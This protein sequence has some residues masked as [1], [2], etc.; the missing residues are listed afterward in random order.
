MEDKEAWFSGFFGELDDEAVKGLKEKDPISFPGWIAG[1]ASEDDAKDYLKAMRAAE[2]NKKHK[3]VVIKVTGAPTVTALGNRLVCHRLHGA[4]AA[5]PAEA[6]GIVTLTI[7]ADKYDADDLKESI[8]KA[9]K[10]AEP[11]AP[12]APATTGDDNKGTAPEAENQ[13]AGE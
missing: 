13:N 4:V 9:N 5:A 11:P 3:Q 10:P 1:W 12:A 2:E 7:T 6:D 8:E